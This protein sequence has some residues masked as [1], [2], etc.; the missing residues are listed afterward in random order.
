VGAFEW[1]GGALGERSDVRRAHQGG[2][3]VGQPVRLLVG[4]RDDDDRSRRRDRPPARG[5]VGGAGGG[6]HAKHARIRQM[7]PEGVDERGYAAITAA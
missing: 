4:P 6:R 7:G 1:Q 3:V 5:Q 2:E